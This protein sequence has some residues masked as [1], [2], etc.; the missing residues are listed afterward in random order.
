MIFITTS[1]MLCIAA[2]FLLK[3]TSLLSV[4]F[5]QVESRVMED[6]VKYLLFTAAS[7]PF[8]AIYYSA[9]AI[10]FPGIR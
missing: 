7:F 10:Y 9:A 8:L 5:G 3:G 1:L 4:I 2:A 6:A